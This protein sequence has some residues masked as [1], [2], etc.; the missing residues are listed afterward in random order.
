MI[1]PDP[2]PPQRDVLYTLIVLG[3]RLYLIGSLVACFAL[4]AAAWISAQNSTEVMSQSPF[5]TRR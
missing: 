4:I 5:E 2:P 1:R 3:W